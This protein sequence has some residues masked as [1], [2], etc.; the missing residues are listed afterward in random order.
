MRGFQW[1]VWVMIIHYVMYLEV[2]MTPQ[3]SAYHWVAWVAC[4]WN[5][6]GALT[7][8]QGCCTVPGVHLQL[9]AVILSC[10]SIQ[11]MLVRCPQNETD[12]IWHMETLPNSLFFGVRWSGEREYKELPTFSGYMGPFLWIIFGLSFPSSG[13]PRLWRLAVCKNSA[14]SPNIL[15]LPLRVWNKSN[16]SQWIDSLWVQR[17]L[18]QDLRDL[19]WTI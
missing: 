4:K 11:E 9:S 14:L 17:A 6:V 2:Q 13:F 19:A 3:S 18:N 5:G 8:Y 16:R 10:I 1:F 12:F 15:M 7:L